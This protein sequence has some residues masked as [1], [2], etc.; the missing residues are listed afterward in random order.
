MAQLTKFGQADGVQQFCP[1]FNSYINILFPDDNTTEDGDDRG[2]AVQ[3][4]RWHRLDEPLATDYFTNTEPCPSTVSPIEGLDTSHLCTHRM[5]FNV[6]VRQ[7]QGISVAVSGDEA[8]FGEDREAPAQLV[9]FFASEVTRLIEG[10]C[11]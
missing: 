11:V 8:L 1:R 3:V 2:S 4:L 6:T 5:F 7:G 9:A 10:A